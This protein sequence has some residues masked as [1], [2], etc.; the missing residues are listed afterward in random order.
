MG[1]EEKKPSDLKL[2]AN[3]RNAAKS[4]GPR[5][6]EGK[7]TS[8]RNAVKHGLLAS[9]ML[10]QGLENR[11]EFEELAAEIEDYYRPSPGMESRLVEEII[12]CLWR[13]QRARRFE[14]GQISKAKD[15]RLRVLVKNTSFEQSSRKIPFAEILIEENIRL[16]LC[17]G[18]LEKV[19]SL[20]EQKNDIKPAV[21]KELRSFD[22]DGM[23]SRCIKE[24][25]HRALQL[26]IHKISVVTFII[27]K[28]LESSIQTDD[29]IGNVTLPDYT[30][31]DRLLRYETSITKKLYQAMAQLERLQLRRQGNDVSAPMDVQVNVI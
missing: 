14:A 27:D 12:A 15:E 28:S 13:L 22:R 7:L 16:N 23:I 29:D 17:R 26:I 30:D 25:A 11:A 19:K 6:L 20:L 8:S 10:A 4:T 2:E 5:S 21:L 9:R 18:V 1:N 24:D 31:S 3:R